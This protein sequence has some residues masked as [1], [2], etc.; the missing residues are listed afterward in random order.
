MIILLRVKICHG[1]LVIGSEKTNDEE[2]EEY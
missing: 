2:V 1:S